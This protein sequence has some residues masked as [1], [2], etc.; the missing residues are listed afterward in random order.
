MPGYPVALAQFGPLLAV[1]LFAHL[2]GDDLLVGVEVALERG[3]WRE[4]LHDPYGLCARIVEG[5]GYAPRFD[6]VGPFLGEHDL[7]VYVA[8]HLAFQHERAL[9]FA[10]VGVGWD[11][12]AGR[13]APLLDLERT[14]GSLCRNLVHY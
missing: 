10:G 13:E 8:L 1:L 9:V 5:V 2:P 14:S 12:L 7:A 3:A 4:D 11:H 6:D